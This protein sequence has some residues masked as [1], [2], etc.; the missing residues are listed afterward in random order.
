MIRFIM[1]RLG[2][3]LLTLLV[4]SLIIF[5]V[6]NH[7][8]HAVAV[9][10]LGQYYTAQDVQTTIHQLG[11]DRPAPLRYV[12]WITHFVV[13]DWGRSYTL[14]VP[15]AEIVF[16]RLRNS[17]VLGG[18]AFVIIVPFSVVMGLLAGLREDRL[19]D[20]VVSIVG[21]S[22]IALPEFVSGV[23][24]IVIFG[25]WLGWLPA[26][27]AIQPNANPFQSLSALIMPCLT[28]MLVEF[29][30]IARM[31]RATTAEAMGSNYVRTAIVKGLP[32]HIVLRKHVLRNALLP[33][34]TVIASQIGWLLGGLVIVETLFAYPG[35]GNLWLGAATGHDLP[36]LEAISMLMAVVYTVS[37]LVADLLYAYLNPRIR[38]S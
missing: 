17:A 23:F 34:I 37:N 13:G 11:L 20:R 15:V 1:R 18:L 19:L 9:A 35:L 4:S 38:Y 24:L 5:I 31:T 27:A 30:Y 33:V 26:S 25:L 21:L 12:Q 10:V 32:T 36:L 6:L 8:P 22:A 16:E 28:L 29:A 3:L 7:D 14:N 2:L